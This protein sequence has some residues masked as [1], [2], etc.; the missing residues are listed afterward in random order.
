MCAHSSVFAAPELLANGGGDRPQ[1]GGWT[2][3]E[4]SAGTTGLIRDGSGGFYAADE[5]PGFIVLGPGA[6]CAIAQSGDFPFGS[7]RLFL[8]ARVRTPQGAS[9]RLTLRAIDNAGSIDLEQTRVVSGFEHWG[10]AELTYVIP[11]G[12]QTW[13][14]VLR[15]EQPGPFGVHADALTL[16]G[17]CL[18]DVN[19]DRVLNF[20]DISDYLSW[21]QAG[22][23]EADLTGNGV[24]DFFDITELLDSFQFVCE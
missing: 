22:A 16:I 2:V 12:S 7:E 18:A 8:R 10:N 20:F 21:F 5:G 6:S 17:T 9:V 15:T 24:I 19:G 14:L 1:L 11:P 3:L 4:G 23:P 13:D